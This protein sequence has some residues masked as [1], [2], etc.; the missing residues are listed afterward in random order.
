M[1]IGILTYH[2][3]SNFGANL[4]V[5]STYCYL[6][7]NG[8]EP[9]VINWFT[10][11]LENAYKNEVPECQNLCHANF[12]NKNLNMTNRCF[13]AQ[14]IASEIMRLGIEA[15]IVGSDAVAQHF[16]FRS[17]IALSRRTIVH[18]R[19]PTSD[20]IFPNP[21]WGTFQDYLEKPIPIAL[22]SVSNQNSPFSKMTRKEKSLMRRRIQD[23]VFIS[24]RDTWTAKMYSYISDG[25]I[26]PTVTPDPVFAMN[27]NVIFAPSEQD[28]RE[29]YNLTKPYYL[30]SFHNSTTVSS[31]W[32]SDFET[33]ANEKGIECVAFPFPDGITFK[34]PFSKTIT[35]PLDPLDWFALIKYSAGYIGHNMHP[36]VVSLLNQ[37]P[38]FSFDHYGI[39]KFRFFVKEETSKI[40][41]IMNKFGVSANRI[42]CA[43]LR[44]ETPTPYYVFD[45]LCTYNKLAVKEQASKYLDAYNS[46]MTNI[47]NSFQ[48]KN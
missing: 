7:N 33:L 43:G 39:V 20:R 14:D 16:S 42:S 31:Q 12:R 48:N 19:K 29:K 44:F 38:C 13:S 24:T 4:Q 27:Q 41:H 11:E 25:K 36:I 2:A 8:H 15:V 6:R 32:L 9:I 18:L 40:Y 35:L 46:M 47:I 17:R 3:V 23:F 37:V 30:L 34:H 45:K 1:K 28:I 10:E 5:L 21:F 22:M 26:V